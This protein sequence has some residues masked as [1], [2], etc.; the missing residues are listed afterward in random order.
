MKRFLVLVLT[1]GVAVGLYAA[2]A[3]GTQQAVTPQQFSALKKQVAALQ[4]DVKALKVKVAC[5]GPVAV[6]EFGDG[7]TAGYHYKQP[8]GSE[9]LASALDLVGEG[10]TPGGY[11]AGIKTECVS[12]RTLQLDVKSFTRR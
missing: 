1:A 11:L 8:D 2:T 9:I 12:A 5:L 4:K 10:E 6:A 7:T 3:G